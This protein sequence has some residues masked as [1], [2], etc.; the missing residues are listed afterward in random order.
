MNQSLHKI[1]DY[2][3][4]HIKS[5]SNPGTGEEP[6]YLPQG[7]EVELFEHAYNNQLPALIKGPTGCGKTR[8]VRYMAERLD[9]KSVV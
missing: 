7:N 8:F 2:S 1:E 5:G 6:F 3:A 9:R 4:S